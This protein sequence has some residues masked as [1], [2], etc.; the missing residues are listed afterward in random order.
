MPDAFTDFALG[1]IFGQQA[2]KMR[3]R[4]ALLGSD[5]HAPMLVQPGGGHNCRKAF[6]APHQ[7]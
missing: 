7:P 5:V 1:E 4:A 3:Q 2:E 6:G